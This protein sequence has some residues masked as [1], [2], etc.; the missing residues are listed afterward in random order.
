MNKVVTTGKTIEDAVNQALKLLNTS[1]EHVKIK[2]LEEP[3]KGLFGIIGFKEAKIEVEKIRNPIEEAKKFLLDIFRTMD[4]KCNIEVFNKEDH[5]VLN[6]LGNN[7]GIII[8]K[9]GQTLDALQYLT[10]VVVNK[11]GDSYTRIILDAENYRSR[12]KEALEQLG[13]RLANKVLKTKRTI[14]LEPMSPLERKIIHTYLQN[15]IGIQTYSE[16]EE[17]NRRIVITTDRKSVV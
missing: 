10:N 2:V 7:L 6:I 17:P 8:G 14:K 3:S 4:L 9:R 15:K 13:E 11:H 1:R 5:T 12:R 16:G